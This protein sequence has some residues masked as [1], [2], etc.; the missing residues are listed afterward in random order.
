MHARN[1]D[2][3]GD[4]GEGSERREKSSRE[5]FCH[6]GEYTYHRDQ[7]VTR[8]VNAKGASGELS[9]R[10]EEHVMGHWRK[11]HPCH[12]VA[13]NT[14]ELCSSVSP[15]IRNATLSDS[16]FSYISLCLESLFHYYLCLHQHVMLS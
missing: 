6:L 15:L 14:A 16:K 5:R 2:I 8:N 1:M 13:K 11:G 10:N 4:S 9:D 7:N 3:I 12:K